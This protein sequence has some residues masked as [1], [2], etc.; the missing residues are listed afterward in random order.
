MRLNGSVRCVCEVGG[1][2]GARDAKSQDK[3]RPN[4]RVS[5]TNAPLW[6]HFSPK[7][8]KVSGF[9]RNG[10]FKIKGDPGGTIL[11]KQAEDHFTWPHRRISFIPRVDGKSF[12]YKKKINPF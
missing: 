6:G 5:S 9:L 8:R 12:F 4:L 1:L 3:G 2:R 11:F 10:D 7:L